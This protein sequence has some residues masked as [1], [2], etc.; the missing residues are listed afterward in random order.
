MGEV[1]LSIDPEAD[2]MPDGASTEMK[3]DELEASIPNK[4]VFLNMNHSTARLQKAV[5]FTHAVEYTVVPVVYIFG[6]ERW[7][8]EAYVVQGVYVV[9]SLIFQYAVFH[10]SCSDSSLLKPRGDPPYQKQVCKSVLG[11][12]VQCLRIKQW[13]I[14]FVGLAPPIAHVLST[15]LA[16]GASLTIW[17]AFESQQF[18]KKYGFLG[19]GSFLKWAGLPGLLTAVLV[20]GGVIHGAAVWVV[21]IDENVSEESLVEAFDVSNLL[22]LGRV[23]S[24]VASSHLMRKV[25]A[26]IIKGPILLL[27]TSLL[28]ITYDKAD[29][30]QRISMIVTL[31]LAWCSIFSGLRLY[32]RL[33]I[34]I[35]REL[36]DAGPRSQKLAC[37]CALILVSIPALFLATLFMHFV[38]L[39][40]CDSHEFSVFHGCLPN[41]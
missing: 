22:F 34:D 19:L 39:F 7:F 21:L 1:H 25:I 31:S 16:C 4:G 5:K 6:A 29:Q 41:S 32:V 37:G 15:S 2:A 26:F 24:N 12:P 33:Y 35:L 18:A 28:V 20:V 38:G 27:C 9:G 13:T 23:F 14:D 10:A 11:V 30:Q 17:T 36:K 8:P 3:I 40:I